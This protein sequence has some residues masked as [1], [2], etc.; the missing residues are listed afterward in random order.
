MGNCKSKPQKVQKS[1]GEFNDISGAKR[2][3][4]NGASSGHA[5]GDRQHQHQ[6]T[7]QISQNI[8]PLPPERKPPVSHPPCKL[9]FLRICQL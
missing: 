1:R 8:V 4:E 7:T 6:L 5:S 9:L 3:T 2:H